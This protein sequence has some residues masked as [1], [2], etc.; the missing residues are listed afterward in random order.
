M[1]DDEKFLRNVAHEFEEGF[2][3]GDVDRLMRFY[4]D[5]YVDVNLR[6]P[7]QSKS[8]RQEYY[9]KVMA[10]PG[11]HVQVQPEEIMIRGDLSFVRGS[12]LLRQGIGGEAT[13]SE[14]RYLEIYVRAHDG[15]WRVIW[16]MDGP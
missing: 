13:Q 7:V 12:I 8:E 14:L 11:I 15:T 3:T 16:G 2:N 5:F 10:R 1:T 4:G 6:N 9:A